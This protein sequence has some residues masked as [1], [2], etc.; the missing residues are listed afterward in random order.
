MAISFLMG[1]IKSTA[2]ANSFLKVEFYKEPIL[3]I[4][5]C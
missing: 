1:F 2:H 4:I 5:F 3:Y